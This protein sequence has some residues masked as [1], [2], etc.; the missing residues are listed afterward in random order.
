[1]SRAVVEVSE[2]SV[3]SFVA[4]CLGIA[5]SR[6]RWGGRGDDA[7][8]L[9][10]QRLRQGTSGEAIG[11]S[12]QAISADPSCDGADLWLFDDVN[13]TGTN[14]LCLFGEGVAELHNYQTQYCDLNGCFFSTWSGH[15]RSYWAGVSP[16][17]L[18]E[19]VSAWDQHFGAWERTDVAGWI[20]S[21]AQSVVLDF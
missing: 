20:A 3:A 13:Q 5:D 19:L 10:E 7:A 11:T 6:T 12:S 9:H 2:D 17:Y 16:G 14:E 4:S 8:L 21:H 1:M 15:V 18:H